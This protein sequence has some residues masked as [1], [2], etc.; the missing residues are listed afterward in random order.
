MTAALAVTLPIPVHSGSHRP[1]RP[2]KDQVA[3]TATIAQTAMIA[4]TATIAQ[5]PPLPAP[6]TATTT[7]SA[8]TTI[9]TGQTTSTASESSST[10]V[11]STASTAPPRSHPRGALAFRAADPGATI[12]DFKFAP[13]TITVHA[14][15]SVTWINHGPSTHTATARDGSFDSGPLKPAAS[16]SHTFTRPGTYQYFCT[17]HPFMHGTVVV[18][19]SAA[20]APPPP[21]KHSTTTTGPSSAQATPAHSTSKT[22]ARASSR[23]TLAL[24]GL[25]LPAVVAT[26]ALLLLGG[27][28]L[29]YGAIRRP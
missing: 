22:N 25:D 6:T 14:G 4:Q 7:T 26:A 16:S 10:A 23:P 24:T 15:E 27:L 2:G 11:T 19:A 21:S 18:L 12:S 28:L 3:Q 20:A 13:A 9:P 8:T 17:I 29:R 1:Q 5:A